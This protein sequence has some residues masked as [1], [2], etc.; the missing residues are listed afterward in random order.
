MP[1]SSSSSSSSSTS[2]RIRAV[3]LGWTHSLMLTDEGRALACGMNQA[4]KTLF[5]GT[6]EIKD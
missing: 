6:F 3:S 2:T 4:G 5:V 1:P